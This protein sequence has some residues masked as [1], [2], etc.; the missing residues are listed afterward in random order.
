MPL[1]RPWRN[2]GVM[3][4]TKRA[5]GGTTP[6]A[7]RAALPPSYLRPACRSL[8]PPPGRRGGREGVMYWV[9]QDWMEQYPEVPPAEWAALDR[10][11][12]AKVRED[13]GRWTEAAEQYR[14]ELKD[15]LFLQYGVEE[16]TP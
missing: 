9:V 5:K 12:R 8:S 4:A 15:D 3:M 11:V 13:G 10:A 7:N 6:P 16:G 2:G 1:L 14:L